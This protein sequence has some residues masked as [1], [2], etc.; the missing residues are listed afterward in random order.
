MPVHNVFL[1]IWK[2]LEFPLNKNYP[3]ITLI[4]N[5]HLD[6]HQLGGIIKED[7]KTGT[8]QG[9]RDAQ[10]GQDAHNRWNP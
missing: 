10:D 9:W 7:G 5:R 6:P 1:E 2:S 4:L 8:H 3:R